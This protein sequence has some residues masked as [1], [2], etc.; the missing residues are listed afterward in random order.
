[1]GGKCGIGGGRKQ[2]ET[3]AEN[4]FQASARWCQG[5]LAGKQHGPAL[6]G[7]SSCPAV[8]IARSADRGRRPGAAGTS[9][10]K[11]APPCPQI[12]RQ[13]ACSSAVSVARQPY[14]PTCELVGP[15]LHH[16]WLA[17]HVADGPQSA[18]LQVAHRQGQQVRG[19]GL[20]LPARAGGR[21]GWA[22]T[23]APVLQLA[24]QGGRRGLH[25]S[26]AQR[27]AETARPTWEDLLGQDLHCPGQ[28]CE[29][30][31]NAAIQAPGRQG[32]HRGACSSRH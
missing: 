31:C 23:G 16:L 22:V 24:L 32:R 17:P 5:M 4:I 13:S 6:V 18:A 11:P 20:R 19:D 9:R 14:H 10:T 25:P 21:R 1:M 7:T 27:A 28:G 15:C 2:G 3:P 29:S 8:S 12:S 30:L 26:A